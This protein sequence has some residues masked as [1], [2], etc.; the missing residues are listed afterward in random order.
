MI[1]EDTHSSTHPTRGR[2]PRWAA[3]F[4]PLL[5]LVALAAACSGRSSSPGV[6]DIGSTPTPAN[7]SSSND[8][9][10]Q[11]VLAYSQ[12]MRENGVPGFPD[13]DANGGLSVNAETLGVAPDSPQYQAADEACKDL[14]PP[15]S[16]GQRPDRETMLKYSQ[17]MRDN[18]ISSFPDP[19]PDGALQ[20][21][22]EPGSELDPNT[23]LHQAAHEACKH[24]LPDGGEGG[25]QG[26]ESG[27][28]E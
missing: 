20:V 14:L 10:E 17:C 28:D 9:G 25:E 15:A 23:P 21:Q 2:I 3:A 19:N 1:T 12:C 8:S 4:A 16:Q 13:P 5:I 24:L 6:A 11:S 22:A 7:G 26:L 18:G 27:A